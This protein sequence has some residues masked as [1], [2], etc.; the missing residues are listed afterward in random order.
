M[1][2]A[3]DVG[4]PIF[5]RLPDDGRKGL[6]MPSDVTIGVNAVNSSALDAGAVAAR[7]SAASGVNNAS[8]TVATSAATVS[9]AALINPSLHFDASFNLVVLEFFGADGQVSS[10]IPSQRQLEAY[11]VGGSLLPGQGSGS[12]A[13]ASAAQSNAVTPG[14]AQENQAA[15]VPEAAFA[16]ANP[17]LYSG[18]RQS[19]V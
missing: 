7:G 17:L 1:D 10:T 14:A 4:A 3:Q 11:R 12:A 19:A 18:T 8:P 16:P 13:G 9:S 6:T 5:A 2:W 15:G